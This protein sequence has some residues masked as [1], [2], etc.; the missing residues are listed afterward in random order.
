[1]DTKELITEIISLP[2]DDRVMIADT[3]LK[4]LN[5]RNSEIDKKWIETAKRRAS[6]IES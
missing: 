1:M 4:S 2:V 6:E 5:P 3:I